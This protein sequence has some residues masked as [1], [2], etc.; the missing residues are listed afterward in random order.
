MYIFCKFRELW[1]VKILLQSL[2][3]GQEPSEA[4]WWNLLAA[5]LAPSYVGDGRSAIVVL[6]LQTWNDVEKIAVPMRTAACWLKWG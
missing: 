5:N 2:A 3:D 6:H 1:Q 4:T